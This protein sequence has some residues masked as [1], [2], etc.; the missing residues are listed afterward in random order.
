M[1]TIRK[2]HE[3]AAGF[4]EKAAEH[5]RIAAAQA[6]EKST[7]AAAHHALAAHGFALQGFEHANQATRKHAALLEEGVEP[8]DA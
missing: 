5:H 1:K 7:E 2:L 8:D 6:A 4:F 3:A